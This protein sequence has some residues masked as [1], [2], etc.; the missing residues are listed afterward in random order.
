MVLLCQP[1][2]AA[3]IGIGPNEVT[4]NQATRGGTY[5]RSLTIFNPADQGVNINVRTEGAAGDWI[6]LY[7]LDNR[8]TEISE[9]FI[10][11]RENVQLLFKVIVPED[12]PTEMYQARIVAE[13]QSEEAMAGGVGTVLRA[14]SV[15]TIHVIGRE[16]VSGK[17]EG[18]SV[19]NTETGVPLVIDVQFRNTGNVIVS[20]EI[21]S[22]IKKDGE[23]IGEARS[24]EKRVTPETIESILVEWSTEGLEPGTYTANVVGM[25]RGEQ[26]ASQEMDF[27]VFPYGQLSREGTLSDLQYEG[28]MQTGVPIKLNGIFTN[29]GKIATRAVLNAEIYQ[30]GNFINAIS[31]DTVLVPVGGRSELF[32]YLTVA[33]PGEYQIKYWALYEGQRT[34]MKDVSLTVSE[35]GSSAEPQASPLSPVSVIGA[36][37]MLIIFATGGR[38]KRRG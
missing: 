27:E 8:Q 10:P 20:P 36:A 21:H 11:A 1:A 22:T 13:T 17:V 5:E 35:G 18:I 14:R 3:G 34:E 16:I 12:T 28:M 25:L 31:G 38:L 6:A 24:S 15:V 4:I 19:A 32:S 29:T 2:L 9:L 7:R 33:E 37:M 26:I 30:N 23:V